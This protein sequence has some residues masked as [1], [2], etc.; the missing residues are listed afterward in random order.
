MILL[1]NGIAAVSEGENGLFSI[2]RMELAA[3]RQALAALTEG[4]SATLALSDAVDQLVA[5]ARTDATTSSQASISA[6]NIAQIV[7]A[8]IAIFCLIAAVGI[9]WLY[10]GRRVI[11]PIVGTTGTRVD[12]DGDTVRSALGLPSS[13]FTFD[14]NE[15]QTGPARQ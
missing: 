9:G 6:I 15:R 7:M 10:I 2:R 11:D 12:V 1:V 8:A 4:R 13:W 5:A 14:V 3:T